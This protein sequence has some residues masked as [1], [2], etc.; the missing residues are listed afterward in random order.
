MRETGVSSQTTHILS[1]ALMQMG[2]KALAKS[3]CWARIDLPV[4]AR[5]KQLFLMSPQ[6]TLQVLLLCVLV[7]T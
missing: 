7:Y 5:K 4:P 1:V 6:E 3:G 2:G